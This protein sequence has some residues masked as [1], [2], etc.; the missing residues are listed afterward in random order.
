MNKLK[1]NQMNSKNILVLAVLLISGLLSV[2]GVFAE[3]AGPTTSITEANVNLNIVLKPIQTITVNP[4][5]AG[6]NIVYHNIDNYE[7]GVSVT[8]EKHLEVFSTGGFTVSVKSDGDFKRAGGG[9]IA[10]GDVLVSATNG[11]G[12]L[13]E[14]T[15]AISEGSESN[16]ISST[17]GGRKLNYDVTYNNTTAT[18]DRYIDKYIAADGEK[19]VY[20]ATV[21]YTI[22][23]Q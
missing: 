8:K 23:A 5:Q 9:A 22:A 20:T 16:I 14:V 2:N 21:T 4:T 10:A 18:V 1:K 3:T 13:S 19:S 15:L 12:D 7:K 17:K 6:V 11:Q